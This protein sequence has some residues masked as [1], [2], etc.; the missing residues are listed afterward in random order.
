MNYRFNVFDA[1][2]NGRNYVHDFEN[3]HLLERLMLKLDFQF[4]GHLMQKA[5]SLEKILKLGTTEGRRI[6]GQQRMRS[7]DGI[8]D[9]KDLSSSKLWEIVKDREDWSAAIQEYTKNLTW[10]SNWT[11]KLIFQEGAVSHVSQKRDQFG[12]FCLSVRPI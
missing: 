1:V 12:H 9:S 3:I 4:F 11:T 5:D 10:L 7:L 6:S 8:P 2:R